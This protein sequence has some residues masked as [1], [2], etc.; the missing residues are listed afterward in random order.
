MKYIQSYL[1]FPKFPWISCV[2]Q[3]ILITLQKDF[4]SGIIQNHGIRGSVI[5][6][7]TTFPCCTPTTDTLVGQEDPHHAVVT[8]LSLEGYY[9]GKQREDQWMDKGDTEFKDYIIFEYITG[10]ET[11]WLYN[12]FQDISD[13]MYLLCL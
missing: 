10:M 11:K 2:D 6:I 12:Y 5:F 3:T 8:V 7:S 4:D 13:H 1:E 9:L